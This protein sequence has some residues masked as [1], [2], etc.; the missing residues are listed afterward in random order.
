MGLAAISQRG[1]DICCDG[2][3]LGAVT[4]D[5]AS[6]LFLGA[7][8]D[9][10]SA[11]ETTAQPYVAMYI[12]QYPVPNTQSAYEVRWDS[13]LVLD[14]SLQRAKASTHQMLAALAA[15]TWQ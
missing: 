5:P 13:K 6:P 14:F 12:L 2:Y 4:S 1:Q 7:D 10:S 15:V 9:S 8:Y 3:L 11:A